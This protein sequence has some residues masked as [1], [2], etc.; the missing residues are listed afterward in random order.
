MCTAIY[1][2]ES[3]NGWEISG[4]TAGAISMLGNFE[5]TNRGTCDE[6][7]WKAMMM[8]VY[9]GASEGLVYILNGRRATIE[10]RIHSP[11]ADTSIS[12]GYSIRQ[13][14]K[15]PRL[16]NQIIQRN[17]FLRFQSIQGL[18]LWRHRRK[19]DPPPSTYQR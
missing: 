18:S 6:I 11:A 19:H 14:D 13:H 3:T 2:K 8:Y 5:L 10:L 7:C 17:D 15:P 9:G 12:S 16:I 4:G 1:R